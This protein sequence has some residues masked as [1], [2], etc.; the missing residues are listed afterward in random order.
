MSSKIKAYINEV[1][2]IEVYKR[3]SLQK[4]NFSKF[5]SSKIEDFKNRS[6]QQL[7]SSKALKNWSLQKLKS[8]RNEVFKRWSTQKSKSSK[9]KSSKFK[10]FKTEVLTIQYF[11]SSKTDV[12][13]NK[14]H[15]SWSLQKL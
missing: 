3:W 15:E 8:F 6:L 4:L 13:K 11:R 2:K 5:K 9:L 1:F 12:L 14:T 10:V 7:K